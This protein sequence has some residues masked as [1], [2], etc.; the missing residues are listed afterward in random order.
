MFWNYGGFESMSMC[1][2]SQFASTCLNCSEVSYRSS[3]WKQWIPWNLGLPEDL[4][5]CFW[6]VWDIIGNYLAIILFQTLEAAGARAE[7]SWILLCCSGESLCPLATSCHLYQAQ[8][9]PECNTCP[10]LV[11]LLWKQNLW[12]NNFKRQT[13]AKREAELPRDMHSTLAYSCKVS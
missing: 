5:A 9:S 7:I 10:Y 13:W 2:H 11:F 8:L 12:W 3:L 4:W 1:N 6:N